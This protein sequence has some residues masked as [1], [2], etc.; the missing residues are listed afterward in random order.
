[1]QAKENGWEKQYKYK[2]TAGTSAWLTPTQA[3]REPGRERCS[4]Q[5]KA[6]KLGRQNPLC[7]RWHSPELLLNWLEA[8]ASAVNCTLEE[9]QQ[10]ARVIH[11]SHAALGLD[12][13]PN[14]A[15]HNEVPD[16]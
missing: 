8:W 2:N 4:K 5:S 9:K 12:E 10:S 7:A 15:K 13:R 1:M 11:L 16:R 3:A 6:A 14:M